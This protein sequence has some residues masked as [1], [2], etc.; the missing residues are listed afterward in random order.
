MSDGYKVTLV[1]HIAAALA[2]AGPVLLY[3]M[4]VR[5]GGWQ[6]LA[7]LHLRVTIPALV[8]LWALGIALITMSD[9]AW[10]F[11]QPWIHASLALW[12]VLLAVSV[13][14]IRPALAGRNASSLRVGSSITHVAVVAAL[15][16]MVFKPGA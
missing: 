14:V 8:A 9:D 16:L 10:G 2:A 6:E 3:P 1:L 7:R 11:D 15:L 13:L 5:A 12:V 4:V